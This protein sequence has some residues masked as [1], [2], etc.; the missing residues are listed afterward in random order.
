MRGNVLLATVLTLDVMIALA[1]C[2]AENPV[3][4]VEILGP[5]PRHQSAPS[6]PPPVR[7]AQKPEPPPENMVNGNSN[8]D[9]SADLL[10]S[11]IAATERAKAALREHKKGLNGLGESGGE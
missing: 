7:P 9:D 4:P 1:S 3:R 10:N 11:I 5:I 6:Q 2:R 8:P